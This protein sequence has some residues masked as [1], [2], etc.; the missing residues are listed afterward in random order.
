VDETSVNSGTFAVSVLR[1]CPTVA[2]TIYVGYRVHVAT[3]SHRH[4]LHNVTHGRYRQHDAG[5]VCTILWLDNMLFPVAFVYV[6]TCRTLQQIHNRSK[7]VQFGLE[8]EEV[9]LTLLD[10]WLGKYDRSQRRQDGVPTDNHTAD[11]TSLQTR[12]HCLPTQPDLSKFHNL[13][14]YTENYHFTQNF[15]MYKSLFGSKRNTT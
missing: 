14:R 9:R 5:A 3:I 1:L 15:L 13:L 7:Q 11:C 12:H 6:Q 2:S 4:R 8:Q 10:N